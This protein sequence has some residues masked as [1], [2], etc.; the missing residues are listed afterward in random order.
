[1]KYGRDLPWRR[2][3][4]PYHILVS[5]IML[6]QTRA[7]RVIL[8]YEPFLSQFPDFET[9]AA[10]SPGEVLSAWQG[11]GYNRRA[12]SLRKLAIR[13]EEDFGGILP[14]DERDLRGLPGVGPY[15]AAA[16][17]V[18]AF[19]RPVVLIET[20]V[21]RVYL[22]CFFSSRNG[23]SD[24]EIRPLVSG[25][26]DRENPRDWYNALMDYGAFLSALPENPNRRSRHYQRQSPFEGSV[27]Q[28]RGAILKVLVGCGEVTEKDLIREL[29]Q[30]PPARVHRALSQ[31]ERE[32]FLER[33]MGI[34]RIAGGNREKGLSS[35]VVSQQNEE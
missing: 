32:G 3:T 30:P 4:D 6:Q 33:E 27:R 12:L 9:L 13:V 22:H 18:F 28:V 10:A 21:R 31:L 1:L 34:V 24:T 2:T 16:I 23:V 35:E 19:N 29:E 17:L 20:N 5:E 25:T 7:E 8:K 26:M 11:L 15:T 14:C